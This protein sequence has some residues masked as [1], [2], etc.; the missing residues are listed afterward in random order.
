MIDPNTGQ[1]VIGNDLGSLGQAFLQQ[2]YI[3]NSG[4]AGIGTQMLSTYMSQMMPTWL[5]QQQLA[6]S[7]TPS[8]SGYD[9]SQGMQ[10]PMFN[11][12]DFG[13]GS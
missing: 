12:S 13:A 9:F 8:S 2:G 7:L 11:P 3:P 5:Q 10:M 1:T 6:S 4:A